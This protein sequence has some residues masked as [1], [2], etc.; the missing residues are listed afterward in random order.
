MLKIKHIDAFQA[1]HITSLT[2]L[3]TEIATKA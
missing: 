2:L 3:L 1:L